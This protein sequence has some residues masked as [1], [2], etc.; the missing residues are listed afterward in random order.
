M[1]LAIGTAKLRPIVFDGHG[2]RLGGNRLADRKDRSDTTGENGTQNHVDVERHRRLLGFLE[3][4]VGCSWNA[5]WLQPVASFRP[6]RARL[7]DDV[8]NPSAMPSAA[9]GP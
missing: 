9:T 1:S 2:G 5:S 7:H 3:A 8:R 6:N 4:K